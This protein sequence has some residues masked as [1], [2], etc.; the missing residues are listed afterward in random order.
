MR[1]VVQRVTRASVTVNDEIVGEIGHGLVVL[2]GVA[3]DDTKLD[4]AYLAEKITALRILDDD[5]G[6][7]NLSIK[8]TNGGVLIVS[9]FTLYGD[10][11]RGLR[12]SWIEAAAPEVAQPLYEFFVRQVRAAVS[13]V[14]TGSFRAMMAVELVNDGPVTIMLDSKKLF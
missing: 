10:V 1:A 8:E 2:L 6:K 11:R 5:E 3:R 13:E 14:A 4:A 12:P 7:M 9:Q